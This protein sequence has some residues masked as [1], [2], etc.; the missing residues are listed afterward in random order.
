MSSDHFTG[1]RRL[2]FSIIL[3]S[4]TRTLKDDESGNDLE[5]MLKPFANEIRRD[6]SHDDQN[7]ILASLE[8]SISESD[9]IVFVGGTGPS[10][11]D[12]TSATVRRIADK[13]IRGFG[14][15]FRMRSGTDFAYLSDA[16][17]FVCSGRIVYTIPGSPNAMKTASDIIIGL[18][19]HAFHEANKE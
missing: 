11:Y 10:R 14:E 16:S 13:E 18:S 7:E 2:N 1:K 17:M 4:T 12:L 3:V 15:L 9:I 5:A 8:R 19:D 6:S